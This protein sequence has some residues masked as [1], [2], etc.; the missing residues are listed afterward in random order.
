[1]GAFLEEPAATKWQPFVIELTG[2]FSIPVDR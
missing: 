2:Q 1:M